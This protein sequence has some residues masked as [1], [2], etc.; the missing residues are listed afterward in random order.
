[1]IPLDV[2]I[3]ADGELVAS[4]QTAA[5][6]HSAPIGRS[7]ALAKT[8]HAHAMADQARLPPEPVDGETAQEGGQ[9]GV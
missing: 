3:R 8:M 7:H 1:M 2:L 9:D 6:E 5:F 4:A